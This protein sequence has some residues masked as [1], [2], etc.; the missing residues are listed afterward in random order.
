M[1]K[2]TS[3]V[4]LAVI[5]ATGCASTML[6]QSKDI[7]IEYQAMTRGS[8]REVVLTHN[9]IETRTIAGSANGVTSTVSKEEWNDVI[10]ALEK[11]ELTKLA[12]L[13]APTNKRFYDGA[14]I[15]TLIV[16]TKDT[17]YRSS[18]FDHGNPPAEIA[19]VVNKVVAMSGLDKGRD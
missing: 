16:K 2:L 17:T 7:T 13:K 3:L 19:A 6:K 12:D 8:N 18:S 9:T 11:V 15:A 10:A 14:L 5:I 1:K 4:L